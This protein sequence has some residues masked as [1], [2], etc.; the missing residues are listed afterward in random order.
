MQ[1]F[2]RSSAILATSAATVCI[3]YSSHDKQNMSITC[4]LEYSFFDSSSETA[5]TIQISPHSYH[6]HG[7]DLLTHNCP[8]CLKRFLSFRK[9][10]VI[11][12]NFYS[13]GDLLAV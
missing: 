11:F 10:T 8:T 1:L 7:L 12:N 3:V 6:R 2:N 9:K 4:F 5:L 13:L